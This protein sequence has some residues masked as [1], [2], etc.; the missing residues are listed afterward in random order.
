VID[1]GAYLRTTARFRASVECGKGGQ[2]LLVAEIVGALDGYDRVALPFGHSPGGDTLLKALVAEGHRVLLSERPIYGD[3]AYFGTPTLLDGRPLFPGWDA[4][5][6]KERERQWVLDF[7]AACRVAGI[8]RIVAG[9]GSGDVTPAERLAD[10]GGGTM[11]GFKQFR[12]F[13]D[14]LFVRDFP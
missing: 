8:Q 10:L 13:A 11:I 12:G 1:C 7:V 4:S 14:Y 2:E 3:G 5:W 6:T 9:L